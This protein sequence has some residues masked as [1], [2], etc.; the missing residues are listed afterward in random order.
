MHKLREVKELEISNETFE[1]E[2]LN[3]L[4]PEFECVEKGKYFPYNYI[5]DDD[6]WG[7]AWRAIQVLLSAHGIDC[8]DFKQLFHTFSYKEDL[9]KIIEEK[10]M[11]QGVP[12]QKL[13]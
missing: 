6:R 11:L 3:K 13:K 9:M 4:F 5:Y 2:G 12:K 10:K 1:L 7:C 8:E